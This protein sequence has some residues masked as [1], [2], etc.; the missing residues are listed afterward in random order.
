MKIILTLFLF[1]SLSNYSFA[2]AFDWMSFEE[3]KEKADLIVIARPI[4][5]K[6]TKERRKLHDLYPRG[7]DLGIIAIGVETSFKCLT[8][9]KG[10]LPNK[11]L[12]FVLHHYR[13]PKLQMLIMNGPG[14]LSFDTVKRKTF[15][16]FLKKNK[17]GRYVPV[18]GQYDP[19]VSIL[20]VG[21]GVYIESIDNKSVSP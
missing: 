8:L 20:V 10:S 12:K 3:M 9:L 18:N 17:D 1:L 7:N 19:D 5:K 6:D 16:M 15:L 21:E 4:A 2:R 11:N 14:L 13:L